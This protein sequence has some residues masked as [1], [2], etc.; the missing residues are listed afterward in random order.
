[1]SEQKRIF[2]TY[3]T[4]EAWEKHDQNVRKFIQE[5]S[6]QDSWICNRAL[7]PACYP[8]L[9]STDTIDKIKKLDVD[10]FVQEIQD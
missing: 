9:I 1:M 4:M 2:Y 8:L 5:E 3:K 7:P 6:G 10:I